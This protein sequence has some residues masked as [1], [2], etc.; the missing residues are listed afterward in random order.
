MDNDIGGFRPEQDFTIVRT[1]RGIGGIAGVGDYFPA[2][3]LSDH[4]V[5][6]LELKC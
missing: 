2:T 6:L 4:D 1:A 5:I 3:Q